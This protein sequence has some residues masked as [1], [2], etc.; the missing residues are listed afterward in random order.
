[1]GDEDARGRVNLKACLALQL[2]LSFHCT[3]RL[4]FF[5]WINGISIFATALPLLPWLIPLV[6]SEDI[7]S[8]LS[9]LRDMLKRLS[10]AVEPSLGDA[11]PLVLL[12]PG[13]KSASLSSAWSAGTLLECLDFGRV[14]V[15]QARLLLT[16]VVCLWP[17]LILYRAAKETVLIEN[18]LHEG[19]AASVASAATSASQPTKS[20]SVL[21]TPRKSEVSISEIGRAHV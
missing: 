4:T 11:S 21:D 18:F 8:A 19:A 17:C 6:V 12:M 13:A 7:S 1:M 5:N 15:G 20:M 16:G 10:S 2:T 14:N 9:P 3:C